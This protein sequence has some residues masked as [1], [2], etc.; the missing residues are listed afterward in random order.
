MKNFLRYLVSFETKYS[1][2]LPLDSET[3]EPVSAYEHPFGT[4][5][6]RFKNWWAVATSARQHATPLYYWMVAIVLAVITLVE[7][8]ILSAPLARNLL[9]TVLLLLSLGKFVLVVAFYMHL[10]FDRSIYT[11]VF[12]ACMAIG[13]AVFVAT[14][15]L[16]QFFGFF[17]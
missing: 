6:D 3:H 9:I 1:Q 7:V 2:R 8:W 14:M 10:R 13:I 11:W 17:Q 15:A 5:I 4:L 16:T 12:G